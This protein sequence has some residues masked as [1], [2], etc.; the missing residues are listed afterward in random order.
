MNTW[1]SVKNRL[2]EQDCV[3]VVWNKNRPF[4]YYI[5]HYSKYFDEFEV[6]QCGTMI[7]LPD[8]ITFHATH[9]MALQMPE[10]KESKS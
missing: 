9:W 6:W 7:T 1:I 4:Q 10:E 2:P 3:C 8:P 5:S